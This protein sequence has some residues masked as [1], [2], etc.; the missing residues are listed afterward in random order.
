MKVSFSPDIILRGW[1][2]LKHQPTNQ[3]THQPT[4]QQ[5]TATYVESTAG[6]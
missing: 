2:G 4:N 3:P 6:E 5:S 1:L